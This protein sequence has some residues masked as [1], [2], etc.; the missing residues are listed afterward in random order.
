MAGSEK[1]FENQ[2]KEYLKE[3]GCWFVKFFANS[4]TKKGIPDILVCCNGKFIGVE[5]KAAKG[6]PSE[7]QI[8]N[9]KKIDAAGGYAILLYPDMFDTF[10]RLVQSIKTNNDLAS[11]INY[12]VLKGRWFINAGFPQ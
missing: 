10:K 6:R 3:E 2:V 12:T 7:L 4:Y 11:V 1:L 8:H 5:V 9:L